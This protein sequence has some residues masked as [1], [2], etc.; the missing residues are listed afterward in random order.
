[1]AKL[2]KKQQSAIGR[3]SRRKGKTFERWCARFFYKW[4]EG[5]WQTTRNSGRTDLKGDIYCVDC[6]LSDLVVECKHDKKYNVMSMLRPT[7]A[8]KHL[9]RKYRRRQVNIGWSCTLLLVVKNKAGVWL[10]VISN[11]YSLNE[12][13]INRNVSAV[14]IEGV[15]FFKLEQSIVQLK[16]MISEIHA[17]VM[18]YTTRDKNAGTKGMGR[19]GRGGQN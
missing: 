16:S 13:L 5:Q 17:D 8:F 9:I 10:A 14:V 6:P 15:Y 2:T 4:F 7:E 1:M 19:T 18:E 3:K 12:I 11:K